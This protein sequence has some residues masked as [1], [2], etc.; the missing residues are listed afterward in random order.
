[1]NKIFPGKTAVYVSYP[2]SKEHSC[3]KLEK[4]LERLSGKISDG[5]TNQLQTI[6]SLTS[7]ATSQ[8]D[9]LNVRKDLKQME[10]KEEL[11]KI[12]LVGLL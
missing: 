1:M 6:R 3:K 4:S 9:H 10:K 7:T 11:Q 2:Y 12:A 8:G 5:L